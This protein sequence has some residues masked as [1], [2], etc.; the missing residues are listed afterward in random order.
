MK[1][2]SKEKSFLITQKEMDDAF[3]YIKHSIRS[4]RKSANLPLDKYK[5]TI[6]THHYDMAQ[7]HIMRVAKVLGIDMGVE[8]V[9]DL[10]VRTEDDK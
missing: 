8:R 7:E 3:I 10:D 1:Y 4:I 9:C 5:E 2:N 6:D